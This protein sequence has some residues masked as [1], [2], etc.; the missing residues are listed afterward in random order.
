MTSA[1]I[2]LGPSQ[3]LPALQADLQSSGIHVLGAVACGNL[4][5]E[6]VRLGPDVLVC[7]DA[8][9]DAAVFDACA[10]LAATAPR[11]VV[12][13]TQ[14]PDAQKIERAL[15]SGIHAYVVNGYAPAR[16]RPVLQLAQA[17]FE[18]E[19]KRQAA[20]DD[21]T[22]RF[23]ERKLVDRAKGILMRARQ[24]SEDE[25]FRV[26]RTA[27]MHSNQ[28]V[29]QVSQQVI[30]AA[31]YAEAVNR[32]GQL[33]MLSQR[34]VKLYALSALGVDSG[35]HA[36]LLDESCARVDANVMALRKAVS[37][38]TFGDLLSAVEV[39]WQRLKAAIADPPERA[40][41]A[42][43]DVL[44]E[45]VLQQADQLTSNLETAG[46]VATLHVL[47]VCGRQRMLSQRWAKQVLLGELLVGDAA[48][49]ARAIGDEAGGAF[50]DAMRYLDDIPLST[51]DIRESLA[52]ARDAWL[53]LTRAGGQVAALPGRRALGEASETL[54]A[55]FEQLTSQY[56]RSMQVLMG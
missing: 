35:A 4:V 31:R 22:H 29:G 34:V 52:A 56:E 47:N 55:V 40:R 6:A 44:A 16:L 25:A 42:D 10:L 43:V 20:L 15:A 3:G 9:G 2:L 11:P 32:A 30:E 37:Q 26:L 17:R 7:H 28:R 5:R 39:P 49:R 27:S 46:L 54:L 23:E 24:V 13:F 53:A 41:V 19:Q 38:A 18:H 36:G 45:R 50:D 21:V 48:A 33:R 8:P 12:L 51:H 14:D 1:L